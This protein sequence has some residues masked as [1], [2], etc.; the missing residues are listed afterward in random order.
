M[1]P[2]KKMEKE[3]EVKTKNFGKLKKWM[4]QDVVS[5]FF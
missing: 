4:Q 3:N 1:I 5:V 2:N